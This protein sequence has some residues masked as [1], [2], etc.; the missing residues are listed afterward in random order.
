MAVL[1]ERT[2]LRDGCNEPPGLSS[3]QDWL[4]Y[5]VVGCLHYCNIFTQLLFSSSVTF[6]PKTLTDQLRAYC[7]RSLI[8]RLHSFNSLVMDP[9]CSLSSSTSALHSTN[10]FF[11]TTKSSM[12]F[13]MA[14]SITFISL[15]EICSFALVGILKKS[16]KET[17][18]LN[19]TEIS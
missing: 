4:K 19:L 14:P 13:C 2:H 9:T 18:L 3:N 5:L 8:S 15:M 17:F 6:N 16:Q 10:S 12:V 11:I 1:E 7:S